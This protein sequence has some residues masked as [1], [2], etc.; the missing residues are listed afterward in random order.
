MGEASSS[1]ADLLLNANDLVAQNDESYKKERKRR[2]N[3]RQRRSRKKKKAAKELERSAAAIRQQIDIKT[4]QPKKKGGF[5]ALGDQVAIRHKEGKFHEIS[6]L[7]IAHTKLIHVYHE[8]APY[9]KEK[10]PMSGQLMIEAT[11]RAQQ[12][13]VSLKLL[14]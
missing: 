9:R 8:E 1:F 13:T 12:P 14:Q 3:L 2:Q 5:E 6:A 10:D 11:G 4:Q 7:I